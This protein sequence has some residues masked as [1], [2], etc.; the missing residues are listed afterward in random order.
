MESK[1][2]RL[3]NK[4]AVALR[5][6]AK[7]TRNAY[8]I[9]GAA[10]T[11]AL[12]GAAV[13]FGMQWLPAV[14]LLLAAAVAMDALLA[15]GARRAYLQLIGQ[16]ICTEAA[17]RQIREKQSEKE[18][19]RQAVSD[20]VAMQ[21]DAQRQTE[22]P[23]ADFADAGADAPHARRKTRAQAAGSGGRPSPAQTGGLHRHHRRFN[24]TGAVRNI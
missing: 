9:V 11:L 23:E 7:K 6:N 3:T 4:T 24:Q 1:A 2:I 16:A 8:F 21:Q 14:P 13:Y 10:G 18:R 12:L 5:E 15:L 22:A 19:R 20:L 17:A